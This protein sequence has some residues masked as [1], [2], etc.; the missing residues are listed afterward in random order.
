M[1][2][3]SKWLVLCF[4]EE[5]NVQC[6]LL[7][8]C[9]E[10]LILGFWVAQHNWICLFFETSSGQATVCDVQSMC[11]GHGDMWLST[12]RF[13]MSTS[14]PKTIN[15]TSEQHQPSSHFSS[16][17]PTDQFLT[18]LWEIF[19]SLCFLWRHDLNLTNSWTS[20]SYALRVF[21]QVRNTGPWAWE[22][23]GNVDTEVCLC[24]NNQVWTCKKKSHIKP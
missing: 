12:L 17:F 14:W 21:L 20:V 19:L 13:I 7:D 2:V 22:G 16:H 6:W 5:T 1:L 4:Q 23:V 24:S 18:C 9:L 10:S 15:S 8:H 3:Q 11:R